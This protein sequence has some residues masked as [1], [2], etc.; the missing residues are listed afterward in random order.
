MLGKERGAGT[1]ARDPGSAPGARGSGRSMRGRGSRAP[2]RGGEV[3]RA[4]DLPATEMA[5]GEQDLRKREARLAAREITVRRRERDIAS[6]EAELAGDAGEDVSALSLLS[7]LTASRAPLRQRLGVPAQIAIGLWLM[8]AP[9][10]LGYGRADP[11]GATVACGAALALLGL[12]R[13]AGM[14]LINPDT[15]AML[16]LSACV[17]T[18]LLGVATLADRTPVA[19]CD[20]ALAG[21]SAW[22]VLLVGWPPVCA[23][24]VA[25]AGDRD[26][27]AAR[28]RP[29][30]SDR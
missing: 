14:G 20:D 5:M 2:A 6:R 9:L 22:V 26:P 30:R 10:A 19:A 21:L 16:W 13:R 8:V 12:W 29:E 23:A 25:L 17:T 7:L 24:G 4:G 28:L 11:R 3:P 15:S 1:G 27:T 18:V